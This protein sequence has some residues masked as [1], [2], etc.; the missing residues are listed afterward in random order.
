MARKRVSVTSEDKN[1]RN[2][3]FHDNYNGKDMT[4]DEFCREIKSG[5]YPGYHVANMN[6]KKTPKSNPDG[7]KGNNLG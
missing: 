7:K 4:R 6:G 1:G 3:S 2:E 5:N